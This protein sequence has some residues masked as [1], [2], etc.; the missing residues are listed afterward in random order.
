[1][2]CAV[3]KYR[4]DSNMCIKVKKITVVNEDWLP[5]RKENTRHV[6]IYSVVCCVCA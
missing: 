5:K 4:G 1:M 6:R 3:N 2:N